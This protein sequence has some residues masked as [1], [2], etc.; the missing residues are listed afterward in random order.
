MILLSK[1]MAITSLIVAAIGFVFIG[2][3]AQSSTAAR[4]SATAGTGSTLIETAASLFTV[5]GAGEYGFAISLMLSGGILGSSFL[6]GL[7]VAFLLVSRFVEQLR[8]SAFATAPP[9]FDGY[10]NYSTPD[11]FAD[12]CGRLSSTCVTAISLAAFAGILLAQLAVGGTILSSIGDISYGAG[13]SII[14]ATVLLYCSLGGMRAL[15]HTDVAQG[16]LMWLALLSALVYQVCISEHADRALSNLYA[17][18]L[19]T[20]WTSDLAGSAAI[21]ALTAL[22][23]FSG[24]DIWQRITAANSDKT[25]RS[26]LN[27]SA[28]TIILFAVAMLG[29]S[30]EIGAYGDLSAVPDQAF[31]GFLDKVYGTS[32]D[33]LGLNGDGSTW[34]PFLGA[35][36][37][38]GLLSAFVSTADTSL[39]L[40]VTLTQNEL[41]RFSLWPHTTR[42]PSSDGLDTFT[43]P[44][45]YLIAAIGLAAA[46]L[47]Y[48][49]TNIVA[50]FQLAIGLLS[51]VGLPALALLLGAKWTKLITATL[52]LEIGAAIALQM[53]E[54]PLHPLGPLIPLTPCVL[55]LVEPGC[56]AYQKAARPAR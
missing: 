54:A 37:A 36:F 11:F 22:A 48:F 2:Y 27:Y 3:R 51:L 5:I 55:L 19:G 31:T 34:P 17:L 24:P 28:A 33:G 49:T 16:A 38:L 46:A 6:A 26:A 47:A 52:V 35:L 12:T 18:S 29:L 39:L 41:R 44:S 40:L 20:D 42:S 43:R 30:A 21:F 23:A 15:F 50:V 7:G 8:F 4:R 25:S 14:A 32:P 56:R 13:L 1:R 53:T 10:V 9:R 45:I